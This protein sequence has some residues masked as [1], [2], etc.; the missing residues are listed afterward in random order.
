MML[1]GSFMRRGWEQ[2]ARAVE[3]MRARAEWRLRVALCLA[4]VNDNVQLLVE[5]NKLCVDTDMTLVLA[6]SEL[7]A[8]RYLETFKVYEHK[9]AV[10]IKERVDADHLARLNDCLTSIRSAI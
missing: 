7:E 4:E 5:L 10:S 6:W 9:G 1:D 2:R 3:A 8:A